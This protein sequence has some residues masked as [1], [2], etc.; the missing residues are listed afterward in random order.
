MKLA[1][2]SDIHA[3]SRALEACLTHAD[4][5]GVQRLAVLGDTV[6]YGSEPAQVVQRVMTLAQQGAVVLQG[7]H[8]VVAVTPPLIVATSGDEGAQWTH[9]QLSPAQR[10]F[11]AG[12]PLTH[13]EGTML[14][15]HASADAP[16]R[17]HYV[18]NERAAAASLDAAAAPPHGNAQVRHVFGGHVHQQTLYYRG[19]GRNLM[20]F[21]PTPGVAIPTPRLRS[22]IA[23]VGSVGQP[24][25]GR[26]EAM[27]AVFDTV[28]LQLTFYRVPYDFHAAA[29]SIRAAGLPGYFAQRLEI[30]H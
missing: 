18:D 30:G 15:V 24:R 2:L 21:L 16:E 20:A 25:D 11:L 3:N 14:L 1:L 9:A 29:A 13:C 10:Q 12:L 23:T 4:S 8:D 28:A 27:Y 26:T 19:T 7:N 5:L 17:W 6:G 22:W